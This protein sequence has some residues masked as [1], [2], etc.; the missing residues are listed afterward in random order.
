[1]R[2]I[3]SFGP[4]TIQHI[5]DDDSDEPKPSSG[6]SS[7][8]QSSG[9]T[10]EE[11]QFV[12]APM[13][14]PSQETLFPMAPRTQELEQPIGKRSPGK[15]GVVDRNSMRTEWKV[16]KGKSAISF[17]P[18]PPRI[19]QRDFGKLCSR[20]GVLLVEVANAIGRRQYDWPN[21]IVI[22]SSPS[23]PKILFC[24]LDVCIVRSRTWSHYCIT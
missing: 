1:M 14:S 4:P 6:T 12:P 13:E 7:E 5:D 18:I 20:A 17:K 21:G 22:P 11:Q 8:K 23:F 9:T 16:Y 3:T 19:E 2:L 15:K 24:I 10:S